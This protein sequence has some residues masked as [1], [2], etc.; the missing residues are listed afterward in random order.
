VAERKSIFAWFKRLFGR[1]AS[2][3]PPAPE[4]PA[5]PPAGPKPEAV[6][7]PP[8][9]NEAIR[10]PARGDVFE[11]H[12]H[13]DFTWSSSQLNQTD[14]EACATR[15]AENAQHQVRKRLW[16]VARRFQPLQTDEAEAAL[17]A[18]IEDGWCYEEISG[19]V[20]CKPTVRVVLD[21]RVADQQ[22][23]FHIRDLDMRA[24]HGL[25]LLK[26][27]LA[28]E[29]T[30]TWMETMAALEDLGELGRTERQ[31]LVPFAAA[32]AD[33]GF[34]V[35]ATELANVRRAR[36]MDLAKVLDSARRGHEQAGL[37]EFA[38]AYDKALR[39][40]CRQ[41]GLDPYASLFRAPED[42]AAGSA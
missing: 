6:I 13:A 10:L 35:V 32:L 42:E 26:A 27:E 39:A 12:L 17:N 8:T 36:T 5:A 22:R 23:P 28:Q 7:E 30:Q 4:P 3:V 14:L 11:L 1:R 40:F 34:A 2:E 15:Y 38:S 19:T 20:R 37:F 31:F 29:L 24:E 9:S 16:P 33:D 18:E 41:M 21:P 25:G